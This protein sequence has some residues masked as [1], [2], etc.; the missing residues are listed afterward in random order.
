MT[1]S[2]LF[3]DIQ[4]QAVSECQAGGLRQL[5]HMAVRSRSVREIDV[6]KWD[7]KC[8]SAFYRMTDGLPVSYSYVSCFTKLGCLY[9]VATLRCLWRLQHIKTAAAIDHY[10]TNCN[11][12]GL[13]VWHRPA[14]GR[15]T[16][17]DVAC[18]NLFASDGI[19]FQ[20]L[21]LQKTLN[22]LYILYYVLYY[23]TSKT[24]N[25]ICSVRHNKWN[26]NTVVCI[27]EVKRTILRRSYGHE[28]IS[29]FSRRWLEHWALKRGD[30]GDAL[31]DS[32]THGWLTDP[33][34]SRWKQHPAASS[35]NREEAGNNI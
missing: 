18:H 29:A 1:L 24:V 33:H 30:M 15:G 4:C 31:S 16:R 14:V 8:A 23:V 25:K 11:A 7:W 9:D 6:L 3:N 26:W 34:M 2:K 21:S 32:K 10:E 22:F 20:T 17:I 12:I 35:I 27:V 19:K 5:Y 28:S 13:V